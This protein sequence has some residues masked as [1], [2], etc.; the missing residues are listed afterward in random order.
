MER[1]GDNLKKYLRLTAILLA[2]LTIAALCTLVAYATDTGEGAPEYSSHAVVLENGYV[3]DPPL[4]P[5]GVESAF[6]EFVYHTHEN[7][8]QPES[9]IPCLLHDILVMQEFGEDATC[10]FCD[11]GTMHP[12][13][14]YDTFFLIY[15]YFSQRDTACYMLKP[16]Q[17]M[18]SE[19]VELDMSLIIN[20]ELL[21]PARGFDSPIIWDMCYNTMTFRKDDYNENQECIISFIADFE[22]IVRNGYLFAYNETIDSYYENFTEEFYYTP[23]SCAPIFGLNSPGIKLTFENVYS[24]SAG[25]VTSL[26]ADE[27]KCPEVNIIGGKHYVVYEAYNPDCTV[28]A[29]VQSQNN[30]KC[31]VKDSIIV[32]DEDGSLVS[33]QSFGKYDETYESKS[34]YTFDGCTIIGAY[35]NINL[36]PYTNNRTKITFLNSRI[37]G[38]IT[39]ELSTS[40]AEYL[41]PY[42]NAQDLALPTDGDRLIEIGRFTSYATVGNAAEYSDY[43]DTITFHFFEGTNHGQDSAFYIPRRSY[44]V[45]ENTPVDF[46][47]AVTFYGDI[48]DV[49]DSFTAIQRLTDPSHLMAGHSMKL[50]SFTFSRNSTHGEEEEYYEE[51][52]YYGMDVINHATFNKKIVNVKVNTYDAAMDQT[53]P[54]YVMPGT[55]VPVPEIDT[56]TEFKTGYFKYQYTG[57]WLDANGEVID[58]AGYIAEYDEDR[59]E[60]NEASLDDVYP[61]AIITPYLS[62]AGYNL[63][64]TTDILLNVVIPTD[65]SGY[66]KI[67]YV[68]ANGK[69]INAHPFIDLD[70]KTKYSYAIARPGTSD[71]TDTY[72]AYVT[73]EVS[74]PGINGGQSIII[75]QRIR[76]LSAFRYIKTVLADSDKVDE[77]ANVYDSTVHTMMADLLRY[78]HSVISLSTTATCPAE[79]EALYGAYAHLCTPVSSDIQPRLSAYGEK[80][81]INSLAPYANYVTF[82]A[83][84][85]SLKP[86]IKFKYDAKVT[87]V[88][89]ILKEGWVHGKYSTNGETWGESR[90][91]PDTENTIYWSN[92]GSFLAKEIDGAWYEVNESG[93]VQSGAAIDSALVSRYIALVSPNGLQIYNIEKMLTIAITTENGESAEGTYSLAAYYAAKLDEY[94]NGFV[95]EA[96]MTLI[97]ELVLNACAFGSSSASYRF[98]EAIDAGGAQVSEL[99]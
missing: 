45:T 25:I 82:I 50:E 20:D 21:E 54:L 74:M 26:V 15:V 78:S 87:G 96:T 60:I 71:L 4:P 37:Y 6:A 27:E 3:Y 42:T 59:W 11:N 31:T 32:V 7:G 52:I 14:N 93:T 92:D 47:D 16:M 55:V 72:E 39:P 83:N 49:E 68:T 22:A 70:G 57:R 99:W 69:K 62:A 76:N 95:D 79:Q 97:N 88:S 24:A 33:S 44:T 13:T 34:T 19:P 91:A 5:S 98:G 84:Y 77:G 43:Y 94:N 61:E 29:L 35:S 73:M 18:S 36:I 9:C 17:V 89:F 75:E 23:N 1:E 81:T 8:P 10:P 51:T 30:V 86:I 48:Y 41:D 63:T 56:E 38:S 66:A 12:L 53:E 90:F 2:I 28:S 58:F 40:D 80:S 85:T 64:L 65:E 67:L 46:S